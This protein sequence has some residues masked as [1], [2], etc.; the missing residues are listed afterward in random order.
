MN[1][2]ELKNKVEQ[3]Q[4][5]YNNLFNLREVEQEKLLKLKKELNNI[6]KAQE[7][8]QE[9]ATSVQ[10]LVHRQIADIVNKCLQT[11][12]GELYE[13]SIRFESKRGKTE[14]ELVFKRAGKERENI[15]GE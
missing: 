1:E 8:A 13:F 11:V 12:F 15:G 14:A 2:V 6:L 7:I 3:L 9:A 4:E 10:K 5:K